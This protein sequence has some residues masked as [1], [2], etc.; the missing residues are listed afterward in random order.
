MNSIVDLVICSFYVLAS[1]N[2]GATLLG[3]LKIKSVPGVSPSALI[4]TAFLLGQVGLVAIWT[5]LGLLAVFS[6]IAIKTILIICFLGGMIFAWPL[7]FAALSSLW[8]EVR[9]LSGKPVIWK[10]IALLVLLTISVEGVTA[11]VAPPRGDAE[12]FYLPIAKVMAASERLV[13]LPGF[14]AFSQ[15]GL[16][17]ELHFAVLIS[18]GSLQAAKLYVWF[19]ALAAAVI[20]VGIGS[21][22]GLRY[23]GQLIVLA[24]VFTSSTF[25]DYISDGKVDLFAAA[26]GLTAYYWA[27]QFGGG[28]RNSSIALIGLFSGMSIVAKLP[29]LLVV[30]PAVFLLVVWRYLAVA[31][32]RFTLRNNLP[33]ILKLGLY[34]AFWVV[35]ALIPN[36]IKN[37]ALFGQ[38]LAPFV[39]SGGGSTWVDQTWF[40]PEV[41]RWILMT[42]P[43][44]LVFGQ[45]PMQGGGL[46]VLLLVL[47]PFVLFLPKPK[48][49]FIS[50]PFQLTIAALTGIILWN[51]FRAS[52]FAPRYLLASLL[53][54]MPLIAYGVEAYLQIEVKPRW[55]SLIVLFCVV[56]V[57]SVNFLDRWNY[58]AAKKRA[59]EVKGEISC[60]YQGCGV[61]KKLNKEAESGDRIYMANW[62]RFWLRTDLLQCVSHGEDIGNFSLLNTPED[63]W[64]FLFEHGFR[65]VVLDETTQSQTIKALDLTRIPDWLNVTVEKQ[66]GANTLLSLESHDPARQPM[67]SCQQADY[68]AWE[69]SHSQ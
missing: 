2:L 1:V 65:F 62:Y 45:Y 56:T 4:A 66:E 19:T 11:F 12:A 59:F 26:L 58:A 22:I 29:Y 15:T 69:V 60:I 16:F 3:I 41:T 44:S 57:L 49:F 61:W 35:L 6:P 27:L 54:F 64:K 68:P 13:A 51:I 5:V 14:E 37:A 55:L 23:R 28:R 10:I 50:K 48:T 63:R 31:N 25:F 9:F 21:Q 39:I 33:A 53:L 7:Y 40:S 52:V 36:L 30:L 67:Y 47:A 42:Y 32:L 46:S 38:P 43:L 34:L 18:M 8:T 20:L 17:G 24:M